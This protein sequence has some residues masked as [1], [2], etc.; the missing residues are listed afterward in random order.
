MKQWGNIF[1][2]AGISAC[3]VGIIVGE[4]FG[5]PLYQTL[6]IPGSALLEIVNRS[7][8]QASLSQSGLGLAL[9][10]AILIG[11]AHLTTA[12]SL[13]V[14]QSIR[15]HETVELFTHK[16]PALFMYIFG[17]GFGI[18]FIGAHYSFQI[19][20][21]SGP[22][23]L[24]GIP[25][26]LLGAVSIAGVVASMLGLMFGKG[27]AVMAGKVH[28]ESAG[29]ALGNG[30]IE[31]FERISG[32]M[33]NTISYVRLAIML[34]I[35][36]ELLLNVNMLLSLPIYDRVQHHDRRV[37][38]ADRVHPGPETPRVRVLHEVLP[39]DRDA[40]QEAPP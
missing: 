15:G 26:S 20:S 33:A 1:L 7:A 3:V 36:A 35:H 28:G 37:R 14:V 8:G 22:A 13:D 10:I 6:H 11:V 5:F 25:N 21:S 2:A 23:P 9:E 19:L 38:G 30:A 34:M 29:A 24:L 27:V 32:Y 40:I 17:V 31:V 12:L 18:S 16:L 39:G 4:F